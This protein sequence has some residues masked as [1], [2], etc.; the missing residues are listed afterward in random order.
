MNENFLEEAINNHNQYLYDLA[1]GVIKMSQQ[2]VFG[3]IQSGAAMQ[4]A[5]VMKSKEPTSKQ[6]IETIIFGKMYE[7]NIPKDCFKDIKTKIYLEIMEESIDSRKDYYAMSSIVY[8]KCDELLPTYKFDSD[9]K[10]LLDG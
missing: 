3:G 4:A 6:Y 9:I 8:I 10:E 2:V 5:S 7:Y 1:N